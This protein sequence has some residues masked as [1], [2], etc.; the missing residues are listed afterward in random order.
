M[1]FCLEDPGAEAVSRGAKLG[2]EKL[3]VE[4]KTVARPGEA[5]TGLLLALAE[6]L[7]RT[8]GWRHL[9][10]FFRGEHSE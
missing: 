1:N 5:E 9:T 3:L 6:S 10:A 7:D 2:N 4:L 8:H